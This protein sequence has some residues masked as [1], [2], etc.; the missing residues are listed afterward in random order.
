MR[1]KCLP[2]LPGLPGMPLAS[3]ECGMMPIPAPN[4]CSTSRGPLQTNALASAAH[5]G[6]GKRVHNALH[7]DFSKELQP[8]T[9]HAVGDIV[10]RVHVGRMVGWVSNCATYGVTQWPEMKYQCSTN[11]TQAE[12][13]QQDHCMPA[14]AC[15]CRTI[16]ESSKYNLSCACRWGQEDGLRN[17]SEGVIEKSA[18]RGKLA[19]SQPSSSTPSVALSGPFRRCDPRK[20]HMPRDPK[21]QL[22]HGALYELQRWPCRKKHSSHGF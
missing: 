18:S 16:A 22:R 9:I 12:Q 11:A 4:R 13:Y 2:G 7:N 6:D 17:M 8:T 3:P 19:P 14:N 1:K 10:E 5:I 20:A 15:R 21:N